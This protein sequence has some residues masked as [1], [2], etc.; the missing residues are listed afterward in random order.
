MT[1]YL[2]SQTSSERSLTAAAATTE[3]GWQQP[4]SSY[5][6]VKIVLLNGYVCFVC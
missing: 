3:A 5:F 6:T 4:A 1:N 2:E